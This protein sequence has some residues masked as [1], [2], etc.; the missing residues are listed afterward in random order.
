MNTSSSNWEDLIA[1]GDGHDDPGFAAA[2]RI[3][4]HAEE[5]EQMLFDLMERQLRVV[6]AL[7]GRVDGLV[8]RHERLRRELHRQRVRL[9][10]LERLGQQE[11]KTS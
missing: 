9:E 8:E 3:G 6:T 7:A 1:I 10:Q 2:A 5:G 4:K 11:V